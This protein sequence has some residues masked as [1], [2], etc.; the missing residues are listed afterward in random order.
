MLT[1]SNRSLVFIPGRS[2]ENDS[3]YWPTDFLKKDIPPARI[4]AF[5]YRREFLHLFEDAELFNLASE[6]AK[7]CNASLPADRPKIFVAY[8]FGALIL[9]IALT[10]NV[11]L[12]S[13]VLGL[14]LI[15]NPLGSE[16]YES[17]VMNPSS[18]I[19]RPEGY[20][21]HRT[22]PSPDS[23]ASEPQSKYQFT[24]QEFRKAHE[25]AQIS[26][27]NLPSSPSQHDSAQV[28]FDNR[29]AVEYKLILREFHTW[30]TKQ[31]QAELKDWKDISMLAWDTYTVCNASSDVNIADCAPSIAELANN[32]HVVEEGARA[33]GLGSSD[34]KDLQSFYKK[35]KEWFNRL[36][37]EPEYKHVSQVADLNTELGT[38][39]HKLHK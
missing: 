10:K 21:S 4:L 2:G 14:I 36:L 30:L 39:N 7:Q 12:F 24:S 32:L 33:Y 8:K 15:S 11:T 13:K 17:S 22:L 19:Q 25:T 16:V 27:V 26:V 23:V 35:L 29:E 18:E 5:E 37:K 20:I 28:R 9:Q 34:L 38:I 1:P 3:T 6:F 31:Q